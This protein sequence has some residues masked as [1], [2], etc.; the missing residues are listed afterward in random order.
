MQFNHDNMTGALLAADLVNLQR[1]DRWTIP[2]VE[3][4]LDNHTIRWP[5]V[6]ERT[7][8]ALRRWAFR[9]REVFVA[10]NEELR[11]QA[12][13]ALLVDGVGSVYLTTHGGRRPHLHFTPDGDDLVGRVMAVTAGGLAFFTV[14]AAGGRLGE[15]DRAGCNRVFVD[16]SRNGRRAYCSARCGNTDAVRRHRSRGHT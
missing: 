1:E 14:E 10:Q 2:G 3:A 13:N 12:V 7:S 16:T 6:D 11:C 5:D 9:L 15:C 8:T 4:V